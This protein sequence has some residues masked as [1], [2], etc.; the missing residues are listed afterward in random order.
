MLWLRRALPS[1]PPP[2]PPSISTS[3][4]AVGRHLYDDVGIASLA[5][6]FRQLQAFVDF[7]NRG[8]LC[9]SIFTSPFLLTS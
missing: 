9:T 7:F 5:S 2:P 6:D 4:A 8:K 3:A 1:A